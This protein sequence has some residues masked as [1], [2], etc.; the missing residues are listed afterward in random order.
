MFVLPFLLCFVPF[1]V[2][3]WSEF[4]DQSDKQLR[5]KF[6]VISDNSQNDGL[7]GLN[8]SESHRRLSSEYLT[9]I[10]SYVTAS[11][12]DQIVE[13]SK[14]YSLMKPFPHM[15]TM[16]IFPKEV[17]DAVNLE[18][19]DNPPT[20]KGTGCVKGGR[21]YNSKSEKS[22]NAFATESEFGPATKALFAFMHSSVFTTFLDKLTGIAE[23]I[24]DGS[25]RGAG[26]HQTLPGGFL[27]I[28]ADF[29]LDKKRGLHRRVNVFIFLNPDWK[30]E[31][32]GHLELW[33]R[34]LKRC[35]VRIAPE[36][37]R[38]VV[39]SSTDF[40]Y[41]GHQSPLSCPDDRSRRSL[42]MYY[43]TKTRPFYECVD[44]NCLGGYHS[45]LFQTTL[46]PNCHSQ[47]FTQTTKMRV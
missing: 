4:D 39:F 41:H 20:A 28:H 47:C 19:P 8:V 35:D 14:G 34:D 33:S 15:T 18:I 21:C 44:D 12:L 38:L 3:H 23:I 31:Y 17:L 30:D 25:F 27:N 42:A 37:G 1:V 5:H 46:C 45:T 10:N 13:A 11:K 43:Y 9:I 32:G 29:N 6:R 7:L 22:K 16:D 40:S 26:I 24:P 36:M 2:G